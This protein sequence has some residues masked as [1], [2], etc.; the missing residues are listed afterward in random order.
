MSM[1]R[2]DMLRELE[3]LPVWQLRQPL[4][5]QISPKI[6][7]EEAVVARVT[8]QVAVPPITELVI[9]AGAEL[10]NGIVETER[11]EVAAVAETNQQ[12]PLRLLLS[13]NAVYAFLIEPASGM[14]TAGAGAAQEQE[15]LFKNMLRAMQVHSVTDITGTIAELFTE[16]T[17]KLII[18][19]GATPANILLGKA[20]TLDEWRNIHLETPAHYKHIPV[21]VTYH[22]AHLL[23]YALDKAHAWRDLCLAKKIMQGL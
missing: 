15:T 5:V 13:E 21:I 20:S 2:E 8:E 11:V 22:P 9:S 10:P 18:S 1:T 23:E 16:H 17:P 6:L 3:L 12:R 14:D 19:I 7:A 4:P